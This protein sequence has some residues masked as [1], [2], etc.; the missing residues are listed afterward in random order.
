MRS[1][2]QSYLTEAE[3]TDL[4]RQ[5]NRTVLMGKR[6]Y[7]IMFLM[8]RTGIRVG[9]ICNLRMRDLKVEGRK[10]W[11]YVI[12]KGDKE[13]KIPIRDRQL[14]VALQ[15]YWKNANL[16]TGSTEHMFMTLAWR[17]PDKGG[18]ITRRVV[19]NVVSKYAK[20]AKIDKNIHPH[21]LRHSFITHALRKS[22]DIVAVQQLAGHSNI[23]TTQHY[24]HTEDELMEKA[25]DKMLGDD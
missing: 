4:L 8:Y 7:A 5:P 20:L 14:I 24:L 6:D 1:R 17:G 25:I 13:R 2:I 22:N 11:L 18:P 23:A 19:A 9:E 3:A 16:T 12:G 15:R 10:V 21:S